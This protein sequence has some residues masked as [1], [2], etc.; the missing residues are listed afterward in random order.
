MMIA[1]SPPG[2]AN[3]ADCCVR[4]TLLHAQ[5]CLLGKTMGHGFALILPCF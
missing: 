2:P 3:I 4:L 5:L 1:V